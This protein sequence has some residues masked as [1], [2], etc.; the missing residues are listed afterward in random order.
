MN[1]L[2]IQDY[3]AFYQESYKPIK[4]RLRLLTNKSLRLLYFFRKNKSFLWHKKQL[5]LERRL[6]VEIGRSAIGGG[7]LLVHPSGITI[8][9]SAVIGDNFVIFKGATIGS[10]RSGKR[11]GV[12]RIGNNVVVGVN[13]FVAGGISIGS[14]VMIA[15]NAFVNFDVPDHSLVIGNPGIIKKK[16]YPEKDY[17]RATH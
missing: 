16:D 4:C 11:K 6:G 17:V 10:V 3:E 2:F 12:P 1:R 8:N 15:P 9:P 5:R 7:L 13:A 14:H